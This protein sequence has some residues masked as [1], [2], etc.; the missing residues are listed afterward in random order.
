MTCS[1]CSCEFCYLCGR[2]YV[3]IPVIG[4]HH[5]KFRFVRFL[6]FIERE[7]VKTLD[8]SSIL[9]CPYNLHPEKPWLRRTIRGAIAT[10]VVVASPLIVAGAVTAAVTVLPT[11][12]VYR[13]VKHVRHR[14]HARA[15]IHNFLPELDLPEDH[16]HE[17]TEDMPELDLF[18]EGDNSLDEALRRLR[19]YMEAQTVR[20]TEDD[21]PFADMAVEDLFED[22]RTT[23]DSPIDVRDEQLNVSQPSA[24]EHV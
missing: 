20:T 17:L 6:L 2:R 23:S 19:G 16:D 13:L 14:R 22:K 10:G 1:A 24:E 15:A 7:C 3:K 12:G 18:F 9:G 5:S 8:F 11:V 4:Q 21:F